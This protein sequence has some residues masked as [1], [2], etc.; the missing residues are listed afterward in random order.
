MDGQ[1]DVHIR[2][3]HSDPE[4]I[5]S[6][7]D[8]NLAYS[9][10]GKSKSFSCFNSVYLSKS[11][12][13]FYMAHVCPVI[14][15]FK[16]MKNAMIMAY[17]QT[18]TGKT[19]TMSGENEDGLIYMALKDIMPG[20][21][22]I[23]YIEIY[24]ERIYDLKTTK[25]LKI[26]MNGQNIKIIGLHVETVLSEN[27]AKRFLRE[28]SINRKTFSTEYNLNSSRSHTI[29]QIKS[30]DAYLN[31]IDLAGCERMSTGDDRR[32]EGGHIN[33]S[34]LA[35]GKVVANLSAKKQTTY[36]ESKLTRILQPSLNSNTSIVAICT[37]SSSSGALSE[38]LGTIKF[39][40]RLS[41]IDLKSMETVSQKDDEDS[42]KG[43]FAVM[44]SESMSISDSNLTGSL[45]NGEP[46]KRTSQLFSDE[47]SFWEFSSVEE[48]SSG[49]EKEEV[50]P[51]GSY[52][53]VDFYAGLPQEEAETGSLLSIYE[54]RIE[55]LENMVKELLE[56]NPNRLM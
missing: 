55:A 20:N 50:A 26:V 41:N 40:A 29:I 18:G 52:A 12:A 33:R 37:I 23:S 39:A 14:S 2:I 54:K 46:F 53:S 9:Q 7:R 22:T 49:P 25:E 5:W 35:L 28:C 1:V 27:D 11:T 44:N 6:Y 32:K 48:G 3:R 36:R 38:S 15:N 13:E 24:N 16:N 56:K 45:M 21:F 34:L 31:F 43:K 10:N 42:K 4:S 19:Y 51:K 30:D 47:L 17:G 8:G